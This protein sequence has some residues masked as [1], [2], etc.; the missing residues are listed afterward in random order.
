M[1]PD[2]LP[3]REGDHQ[4]ELRAD[5][6]KRM[7]TMPVTVITTID[8]DGVANAAPYGC[9]MPILRPLELIAL[10][11]AP[12]RHTLANIRA[13]G[14]FVVN[15]MGSP[16]FKEAMHTAK[17]YPPEVDE[18]AEAGLASLPSKHVRAPRIADALGWIEAKLDREIAD[19]RYVLTIG[20]VVCAEMNDGYSRDGKFVESPMVMLGSRYR[21][22]GDS[23][24]DTRETARLF[25]D[26]STVRDL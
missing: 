16:S 9:V 17:N 14:E 7:L 11:S 15:I 26:E 8:R 1:S 21:T 5:Q 22:V 25:L 6:F 13:T 23:R 4:M 18:L 12:P 3:G 24:G 2:A 10:A 19:D 20:R